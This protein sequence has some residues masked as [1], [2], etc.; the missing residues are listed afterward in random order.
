MNLRE[1]APYICIRFQSQGTGHFEQTITTMIGE[2]SL[3][4]RSFVTQFL[5]TTSTVNE[6]RGRNVF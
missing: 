2:I 6:N 3:A 5:S 4:I 1:R